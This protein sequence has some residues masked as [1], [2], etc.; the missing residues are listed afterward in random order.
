MKKRLIIFALLSL[1]AAIFAESLSDLD[2]RTFQEKAA[3]PSE[4]VKSPFAAQ[5]PL[6]SDLLVEDLRLSG[7]VYNSK[8]SF[9]LVNGY[10]LKE[11]D[12]IAGYK[13]KLIEHDHLVLRQLDQV[14][15]LRL[16]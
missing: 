5:K 13:V 2:L 7:V 16:E 4:G 11:G 1:P 9:A 15:I 10:I 8:D 12:E 14:H 6:P 3:P